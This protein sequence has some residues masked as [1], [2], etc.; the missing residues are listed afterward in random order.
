MDQDTLMRLL[1]RDQPKMH[2]YA[3]QF[4][5]DDHLVEEVLQELALVAVKKGDQVVD[6]AHFPAWARK[7]CRN[8]AMNA[9]RKR[10]RSPQL[11]STSVL[12]LLEAQWEKLDPVGGFDLIAAL[13]KCVEKLTVRARQMIDLRYVDDLR[14][15]EIAQRLGVKVGTIYISLMRIHRAL[16]ECIA[17]EKEESSDG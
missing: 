4:L 17:K 15:G 11:L 5:R 12:D 13:R 7:T 9:V 14:S 1:V 6:E 10:G 2:A 8:L 3:W 16:A